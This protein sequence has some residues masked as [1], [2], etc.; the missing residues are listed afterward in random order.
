MTTQALDH[1]D[2]HDHHNVDAKVTFGFWTYLMTDCIMF[3]AMFATYTVLRNNTYG[4]PGIQQIT[5]LPFI[6]IQTLVLLVSAYTS[7]LAYVAVHRNSKAKIVFWSVVTFILGAIFT[8]MGFH[9]FARIINQGYNWQT[10]G[11]LSAYFTLIMAHTLHVIIGLLWIV[12][13]MIQLSYKDVPVMKRRFTCL[14]MFWNFLNI[15]WLI[16]FTIVYLMGAM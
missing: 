4:G 6:F 3:A 5:H 8:W 7:G 10:S 11:F 2:H 15:I 1:H 9:D 14:N 16:I 12:I 13:L